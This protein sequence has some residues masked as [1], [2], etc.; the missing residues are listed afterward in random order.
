[1]IFTKSPLSNIYRHIKGSIKI[2]T[3]SIYDKMNRG[4][5]LK[6][7]NIYFNFSPTCCVVH[8]QI[9]K[10]EIKRQLTYRVMKSPNF[11]N[12]IFYFILYSLKDL[13]AK[14][15]IAK[16][17]V[18]CNFEDIKDETVIKKIKSILDRVAQVVNTTNAIIKNKE[19][20]I[21]N[22]NKSVAF[23]ELPKKAIKKAT[24][25]EDLGGNW[26]EDFFVKN[27]SE[28]QSYFFDFPNH[29]V[30]NSQERRW[31]NTGFVFRFEDLYK[32]IEKYSIKKIV[33]QNFYL[34]EH[35]LY[36]QHIFLPGILD[37][38]GV[39][40][41]G[42]DYDGYEYGFIEL[43]KVMFH[44]EKNIRFNPYPTSENYWDKKYL[45]KNIQYTA[46]GAHHGFLDK[47]FQLNDDYDLVILSNSRLDAVKGQLSSI[48]FVLSGIDENRVFKDFQIWGW[49]MIEIIKNHLNI[50]DG[51]KLLFSGKIF[52][53]LYHIGQFLKYEVIESLKTVR[54][55]KIYGDSNWGIL[56]P[57][58]YQNK[59]LNKIEIQ[60][61]YRNNDKLLLCF[62]HGVNYLEAS[63]PV[64]DSISKKIPFFNFP[65]VV[66]SEN[67]KGFEEIEYN[68]IE[69]L[70]MKINAAGSIYKKLS[71]KNS[72]EEYRKIMQSSE[73]EISDYVF[74]KAEFPSDGGIYYKD[75]LEHEKLLKD[76]IN[77]YISQN[78][79]FLQKCIDILLANQQHNVN[80]NQTRFYERKYLKNILKD[81]NRGR[82]V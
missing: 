54:D 11:L 76:E 30:F 69:E 3:A 43:E 23:F 15:P 59:F 6:N 1:L 49:S 18:N 4:G 37:F 51:E 31:E 8:Y 26:F 71:L 32:L 60:N 12:D 56:F 68:N 80:I 28:I 46:L 25:K 34:F 70:N 72:I 79:A 22:K 48:L 42:F 75:Y 36:T 14:M 62:N 19:K 10:N 81:I 50:T 44:T 16:L 21:F 2:V 52:G 73:K 78:K 17:H 65:L 40:N 58:Y 66:K 7:I 47:K 29:I 61:L 35:F 53:L 20:D 13:F 38:L 24:L 67:F 39:E 45:L 64:V 5:V 57:E 33:Y 74:N 9:D 77:V 63:G 27:C 55:I 41:I 82:K